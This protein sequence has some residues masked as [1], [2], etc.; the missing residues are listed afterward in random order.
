MLIRAALGHLRGGG[1]RRRAAIAAW[2][3]ADAL[4]ML[5]RAAL[6]HLRGGGAK[7]RAA[8]AASNDILP[9]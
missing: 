9:G 5:I 8:V 6:G 4:A 1:A 2:T 3:F 7:R